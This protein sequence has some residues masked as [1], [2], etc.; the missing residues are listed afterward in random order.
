MLNCFKCY[1]W[2]LN[3]SVF[4][5]RWKMCKVSAVLMSTGTSGSRTAIIILSDSCL[6]QN[7]WVCAQNQPA[8]AEN[9]HQNNRIKAV[10]TELRGY[11]GLFSTSLKSVAAA[12]CACHVNIV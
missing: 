9:G 6:V 12:V 5:L 10:K 1:F 7:V 11:L 2:C 8:A 4:S 3:G